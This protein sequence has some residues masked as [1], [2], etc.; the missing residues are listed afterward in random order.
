MPAHFDRTPG[1]IEGDPPHGEQRRVRA[2]V[3]QLRLGPGGAAR[4]DPPL[5]L[6]D[7]NSLGPQAFIESVQFELIGCGGELGGHRR[8]SL[9]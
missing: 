8:P 7:V 9:S 2:L 3:Q 1:I 4:T 6:G 5:R